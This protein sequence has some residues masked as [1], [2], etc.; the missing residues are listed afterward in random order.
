M[1]YAVCAQKCPLT[2]EKVIFQPNELIPDFNN[3]YNVSIYP[4]DTAVVT[5][6]CTP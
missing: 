6:Y 3:G 1:T 4:T 2:G 5:S